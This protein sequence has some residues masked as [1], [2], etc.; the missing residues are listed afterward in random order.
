MDDRW[1]G[2][3]DLPAS[4]PSTS[5]A[6]W[7][8]LSH[9][10]RADL[11]RV[12]FFPPARF[13]RIMSLP[14]DRLNATEFQMV[15]HFGTHV[16]APCHFIADAPAFH[17]IPL[18]RLC[19]RGVL[20]RVDPEPYDVIEP[21]ALERL[22]PA[23][24]PGDIVLFDS[25]W[26]ACFND[27]RYT[28]HVS[29]SEAAAQWFVDRGVKLLAIDFMTPDLAVNRRPPDFNWPVHHILLSHGVLIAE[30]L[31]NLRSL[32]AGHVEAMFL[33]LNIKDADGAPARVVAR[34][35]G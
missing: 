13:E 21:Q 32:P 1:Q 2:W 12:P 22:R 18:E 26:A 31:T 25:G 14:R 30:N 20:W 23:V 7:V 33:A 15:C 28:Q 11:S 6:A 29:F 19:G 35:A 17:Q 34:P 4:P 27:E 10:L 9:P 24:Q 3:R 5:T 16:D 8:D